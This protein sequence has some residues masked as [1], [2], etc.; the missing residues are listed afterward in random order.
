LVAL[1]SVIEEA[2][3]LL[4]PTVP[5]HIALRTRFDP[6]AAHT[7]ADS[8]QVH[9]I[10]MNLITNAAYAIGERSGHIDIELEPCDVDDAQASSY[11]HAGSYARLCIADSGCGMSREVLERV[12]DPFFTTKPDGHGTGL[13]LSVVAGIMKAH[14]GAVN[15][16]SEKDQGSVFHLYF[17]AAAERARARGEEKRQVPQARGQRV[18]YVDDDELLLSLVG[19]KLTRLGYSVRSEQDPHAALLNFRKDPHAVDVVV[20]DLSMPGIRGF[21]LA[22]FMLAIR[23]DLPVIVT[24]GFVT[25]EDQLTARKIGVREL[26]L[27]PNTADELGALLDKLFN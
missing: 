8:T 12:F 22:Q 20:T 24:S 9:Q 19:R 13:G 5:A 3:K 14:G 10:L 11:L 1:E 2:L 25:P 16:Y 27:K 6:A 23:P 18:W 21:D 7:I 26:L 15:A 17:P 4:R